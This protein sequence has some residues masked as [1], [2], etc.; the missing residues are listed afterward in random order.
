MKKI[1]LF[2]A[3]TALL[4][5]CAKDGDPG[6]QGPA[7]NAN[8]KSFSFSTTPGSWIT[9]GTVGQSNHAKYVEFSIPEITQDILDDGMVLVYWDLGTGINPLPTVL[10]LSSSVFMNMFTYSSLGKV[11]VDLQLSDLQTPNT[12]GVNW[13]YKVVVASGFNRITHPEIDWK[14]YNSVS[15]LF[16]TK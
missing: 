1:I 2:A 7:G 5:G 8:V 15:S 6:A 3:F 16:G 10:P 12:T 14:N 4:S 11:E 13:S 9:N